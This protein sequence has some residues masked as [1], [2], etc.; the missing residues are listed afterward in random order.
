MSSNSPNKVE[1]EA[2]GGT[3]INETV[4][5]GCSWVLMNASGCNLGAKQVN[6]RFS[7]A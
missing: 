3:V 7:V 6:L 2:D 1:R 4:Y 5:D